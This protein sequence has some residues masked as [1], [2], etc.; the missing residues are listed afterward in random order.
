M[1]PSPP[2]ITPPLTDFSLPNLQALYG[3]GIPCPSDFSFPSHVIDYWALAQPETPAIWWVS[4]DFKRERKVSYLELKRESLKSAKLFRKR[5][6]KKGDKVMIQT[7]R[8]VEWW[9]AVFGLMR[10]GA[11]PV[12]GTSLLVAKGES[13][14]RKK[15]QDLFSSFIVPYSLS[16]FRNFIVKY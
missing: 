13:L 11:V 9:F 8:I 1:A 4:H 15:K 2:A 16:L 3:Q 7:G 5:G 10:I 6:L 14:E 12:P